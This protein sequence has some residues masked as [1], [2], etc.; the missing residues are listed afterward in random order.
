MFMCR[1]HWFAL[2][3]PLRDRIWQTYR[4]GQEDDKQPSHAYCEAA[5][6]AVTW[7]ARKEGKEPDV[8]LYEMFDPGERP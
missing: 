4:S 5:T 1:R 2:P 3:K 6:Q 8:R 7:L